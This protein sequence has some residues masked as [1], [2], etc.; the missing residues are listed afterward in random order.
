MTENAVQ[1]TTRKVVWSELKK[2]DVIAETHSFGDEYWGTSQLVLSKVIRINKQTISVVVCDKTGRV[3][4]SDYL[5]RESKSTIPH[6]G[7]REFDVVNV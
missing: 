7:N 1:C 5:L 6:W 3:Y 4:K 2:G